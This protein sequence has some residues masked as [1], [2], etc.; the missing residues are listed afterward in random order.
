VRKKIQ[1]AL[2]Y[3]IIV[4]DNFQGL[5]FLVARQYHVT[6]RVLAK[7]SSWAIFFIDAR[8]GKEQ[9]LLPYATSKTGNFLMWKFLASQADD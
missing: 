9:L 2:C 8:N 6:V 5:C 7:M 3:N 1:I 4:R